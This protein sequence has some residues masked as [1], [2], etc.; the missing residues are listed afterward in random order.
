M[1][2]IYE[3]LKKNR[4]YISK[5]RNLLNERNQLRTGGPTK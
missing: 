4:N 2:I 5:R 3:E 1:E